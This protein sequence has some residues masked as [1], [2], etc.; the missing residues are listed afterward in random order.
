MI[1]GK[2]KTTFCCSC[3]RNGGNDMSLSDL[4]GFQI[5]SSTVR[6]EEEKALRPKGLENI[7]NYLAATVSK[8]NC[9]LNFQS[10]L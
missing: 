10:Y 8:S 5:N 9:I 3:P 4:D 6:Y 2:I 1:L 7:F